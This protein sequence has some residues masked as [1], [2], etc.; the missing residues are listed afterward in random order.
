M[1]MIEMLEPKSHFLSFYVASWKGLRILNSR[2]ANQYTCHAF[3][4]TKDVRVGILIFWQ[5]V[6]IIHHE[7]ISST[8]GWHG[9]FNHL[10]ALLCIARATTLNLSQ[11]SYPSHIIP[12]G[13]KSKRA[14]TRASREGV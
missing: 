4:R 14:V 6:R 8:Q 12:D 9:V 5:Q 3:H 10:S 7:Y 13:T 11:H 2:C 1:I